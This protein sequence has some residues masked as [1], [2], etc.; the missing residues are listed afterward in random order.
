VLVIRKEQMRAFEVAQPQRFEDG[1]IA[2]L[3][4]RFAGWPAVAD[5]EELR[6]LIREG[7]AARFKVWSR[8]PIRP[9]AISGVS[10]RIRKPV[11]N[12]TLD[13]PDTE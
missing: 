7:V 1:M 10:D 2:H 3:T 8:R 11:P 4:A 12:D 13:R 5:K 9:A 6:A